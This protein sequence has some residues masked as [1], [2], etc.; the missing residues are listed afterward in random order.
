MNLAM[1]NGVTGKSRNLGVVPLLF[2]AWFL[3]GCERTTH[4]RIK[5]GAAPVFVLSGSGSVACFTVYGPDYITK[6]ERPDDER[7]VLWQIKSPGDY[8]GGARIGKLGSIT[9]GWCHQGMSK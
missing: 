5:G 8:F 2:I 7:F 3:T 4:V 1:P 6:A 9:Y